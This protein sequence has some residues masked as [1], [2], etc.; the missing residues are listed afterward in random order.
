MTNPEDNKTRKIMIRATFPKDATLSNE[1]MGRII[2][3]TENEI[4]DSYTGEQAVSFI[5]AKS[6]EKT[7]IAISKEEVKTKTIF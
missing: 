3:E 6:K 5:K 2:A 7:E 4:V 1:E